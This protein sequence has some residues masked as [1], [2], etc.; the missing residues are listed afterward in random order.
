MEIAPIPIT[1]MR[2]RLDTEPLEGERLG[3]VEYRTPHGSGIFFV[4]LKTESDMP[5]IQALCPVKLMQCAQPEKGWQVIFQPEG[6]AP[7]D[8]P[9]FSLSEEEASAL[10]E[11]FGITIPAPSPVGAVPAAS[12]GE[13]ENDEPPF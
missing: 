9:A 4:F 11:R 13:T 5:D 1:S 10:F 6:T 12:S 8:R 2:L 3:A 7:A